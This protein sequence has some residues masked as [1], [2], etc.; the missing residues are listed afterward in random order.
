MA[1]ASEFGPARPGAPDAAF[2]AMSLLDH[3]VPIILTYNE[4]PNIGRCLER[5]TWARE[6]LVVDSYSNDNT[7][8]ICVSYPNVRVV[9]RRFD[10]HT[11]QWNFALAEAPRAARW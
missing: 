2:L 7:V 4:G 3:I 8:A 10:S 5:L 9:Q 11:E 6:V 1:A